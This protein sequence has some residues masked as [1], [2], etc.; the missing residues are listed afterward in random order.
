M[1]LSARKRACLQATAAW[2]GALI[3]WGRTNN[4]LAVA[5]VCLTTALVLMAWLT[6]VY[7]A[8]VQRTLDRILHAAMTAFTW[9][10]LALI[11]FGIFMPFRWWQSIRGNDP[12]ELRGERGSGRATFLHP[13]PTSHPVRFDRQF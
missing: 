11:Y 7:Y 2:T 9:L 8:P 5:A 10:L 12:L 1:P 4:G 6:P 13:L 3:I